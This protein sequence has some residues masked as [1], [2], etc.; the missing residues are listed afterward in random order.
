MTAALELAYLGRGAVEPNPMVGAILVRGGEEI[1]RG[2][3][4]RFGG[5]HAEIEALR[6]A[7][8]AGRDTR[9]ATMYVTL[10]PC[11]RHGKTPPCTEAIIASGLKR[12]VVAM[13]DPD[14]DVSGR[15][16]AILRQ[17]GVQ[18]E[19]GVCEAQA[20]KLLAAYRKLRA[21]GRPWVICKWAQTADG[22]LTLPPGSGRW[23]SCPAGR[24]YV[25]ELRGLCDGVLVGVGTVLADDP[26][27]T[28]RSGG[29]SKGVSSRP[30]TSAGKQPAR[31]VLDSKLRTPPESQL[32]RT[33]D[34]SPV[35][36]AT[37]PG[38]ISDHGDRAEKLRRAGAELLELP[39]SESGVELPSLLDELGRRQWTY[40]LVEG[41]ATVLRAFVEARLADELLAFV[42]TR[43][44]PGGAAGLPRFDIADLAERLHLRCQEQRR[45]DD[46]RLLRYILEA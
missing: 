44:A 20:R 4:R 24:A 15:G 11:C 16:L 29:N 19:V 23:I 25:H 30:E 7:E 8:A 2:Y 41:G 3:H 32:V 46:D 17:A 35:I 31:V 42:S 34:I 36:V 43:K 21:A 38:A 26:L 28:S 33:T 10:E 39:T 5:P 12:V 22:F 18:V 13:E 37:T 1:A 40:L 14:K 9:G 45:F 27:L 6:V